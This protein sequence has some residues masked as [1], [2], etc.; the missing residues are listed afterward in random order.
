MF[1]LSGPS[2]PRCAVRQSYAARTIPAGK[3]LFIL[4]HHRMLQPEP[5]E[6][7]FHETLKKSSASATFW[8]DHIGLVH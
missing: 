2:G 6:S 5:P 1:E 4:D 8:A 3:T 7:G